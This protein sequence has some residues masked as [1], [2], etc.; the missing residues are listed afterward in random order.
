MKVPSFSESQRMM[1][2]VARE[3]RTV[4]HKKKVMSN[5]KSIYIYTEKGIPGPGSPTLL[6]HLKTSSLLFKVLQKN[7]CTETHNQLYTKLV[8]MSSLAQT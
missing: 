3:L 1:L 8:D 7:E 4:S 6:N 2:S 5:G